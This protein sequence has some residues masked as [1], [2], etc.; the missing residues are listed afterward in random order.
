MKTRIKIS[1][2]I[3]LTGTTLKT[4]LY[5]HKVGLLKEPERSSKG[6]RLYGPEDLNRMRTI[7][8]LKSLGLDLKR[9]KEI[10]GDIN[11]QKAMRDVMQSL[12]IE[13]LAGKK[14]LEERLSKIEK[15]MR[16]DTLNLDKDSF[17]S[18]SFQMITDIMGP[19]QVGKYARTCP[20]LYDQQRRVYGI[21]DDY[22]W[23]EDYHE[24][25]RSL[26]EF[27]K[28]HPKEYRKSLN[29]GVR[30]AGLAKR[31]EDDPEVYALS[32]E[33][34]EFVKSVPRLMEILGRQS[35]MKKP[36][37]SLYNTMLANIISPAQIK[38]GLLFQQYLAEEAGKLNN[39]SKK[40]RGVIVHG[41]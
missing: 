29:Y 18:H 11:N 24:T 10:L 5:Y 30:L 19:D 27:F 34:A 40:K 7:K 39:R 32:R 4:V 36:L 8:Y 6:Y 13:L 23:G 31:P 12:K 15:L 9:I 14:S 22:D 21:L 33:S 37:A 17:A 3:E 28:T 1:D 41:R 25:F 38:F 26:A 16:E 35:M 20:E 2:F